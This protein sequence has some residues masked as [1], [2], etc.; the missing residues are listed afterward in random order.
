MKDPMLCE[1]WRPVLGFEGLYEVSSYGRVRSLS[2]LRSAPD[3][4]KRRVIGKILK[5][6]K[7]R[8]YLKV[9]LADCKRVKHRTIHQLVLE[10][11]DGPRPEGMEARHLNGMSFDN[12]LV[13]LKWGT[14]V[15]NGKDKRLHQRGIFPMRR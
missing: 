4:R 6:G 13:N 2:R 15:E 7:Q 10:A 1:V 5:S 14:S 11:F 9:G 12:R 3:G 8:E